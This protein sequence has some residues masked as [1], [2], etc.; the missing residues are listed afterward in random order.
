MKDREVTSTR[1]PICHQPARRRIRWFMNNPKVYFSVSVCDEH[2]LVR[3]KIRIHKTD[4][5]KYFAVKT[6]RFTDT[7]EA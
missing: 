7:E 2:G 5:E 1:C 6:L 3:G 4:E